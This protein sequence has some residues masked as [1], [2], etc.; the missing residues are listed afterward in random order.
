ML[1]PAMAD[2]TP[3]RTHAQRTEAAR[4]RREAEALRA[5]LA[6]RKA[7]S[8]ERAQPA[9]GQG[10]KDKSEVKGFVFEKKKQKTFFD[11]GLRRFPNQRPK[12]T[13]VFLLLFLQKK[14][15]SL[16]SPTLFATGL[17]PCP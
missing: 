13:K 2:P 17:I 8:R 1:C 15:R 5:N 10:G 12:L 6:R 16:P 7:Q 4:K 3:P 14:K 11:L 9:E